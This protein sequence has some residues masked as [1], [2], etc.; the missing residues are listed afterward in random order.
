MSHFSIAGLQLDLPSGNNLEVIANEIKN[1]KQRFPWLNMV[2]LSELCTY[3]PEKKYADVLPNETEQRYCQIAKD[4]D[5][6]LIPG[7]LYEQVDADVFN[8]TTVINNSGDIVAR[9]RKIYP[10]YP[11]ESGVSCGQDFVVFDVPQGRIGV[12]ICYDLWF[13]EVAR[14]LTSMGAE[15]L[16][17]PTLTGT[18]DRPIELAMA[19]ATA[20]INQS[21]VLTINTAG[22]LGNGQSI[23]VGPDGNV[24]YQAGVGVEKIPIEVDFN[25]V[26]RNRERG[27]HGLGQPLK[28]FAENKI[29][30][31]VY[32]DKSLLNKTLLEFGPLAIPDMN[33]VK[34]KTNLDPY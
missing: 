6:W 14:Q 19:Q 28:S 12:A 15:V 13:P 11:Y 26:R 10:F 5:L 17:Y 27:L 4:N 34:K 33:T 9:Y 18:I 25:L 29:K 22:E 32:E 24:I 31:S 2:V 8:T 23:V 16:I 7:S 21:Y 1:I 20:A 30:F 3:G